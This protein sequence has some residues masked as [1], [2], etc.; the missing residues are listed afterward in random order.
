MGLS[1]EQRKIIEERR[2]EV[3]IR[4]KA[5][6]TIEQIATALNITEGLVSKDRTFLRKNGILEI[7]NIEE[8]VQEQ[9]QQIKRLAEAGK[10]EQEIAKEVGLSKA[11]V[12][13]YKM[14]LRDECNL[15]ILSS[16]QRQQI[17]EEEI[18]ARK[19]AK[20]I[21][22]ETGISKTA[23]VRYKKK[24]REQGKLTGKEKPETQSEKQIKRRTKKIKKMIEDEKTN[25]EMEEELGVSRSTIFRGKRILREQ[26]IAQL[27]ERVKKLYENFY[28]QDDTIEKFEEYLTLCKERYEQKMIDEKDLIAIKCAAIS[29]QRYENIAFYLKLCI[30]FNQFEEAIR[31]AH[32]YINYET[33]SQEEKEK[34][35]KSKEEC[36]KYLKAI[37]MIKQ[38]INDE[39]I[40]KISGVSKVELAILKKKAKEQDEKDKKIESK[41]KNDNSED[42]SL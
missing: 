11:S 15:N 18:K 1:L 21:K 19:T 12:S 25:K 13:K 17:V 29:T 4:T 39:Q 22:K 6:E 30:R 20:Q 23:I 35:K 38:K 5:G 41:E 14:R 36:Q 8:K 31:L 10:T 37:N 32:D 42:L 16:E 3:E 2:K 34:I 40:M 26:E 24:L 9:M 27:S 28:G 7:E 33:F